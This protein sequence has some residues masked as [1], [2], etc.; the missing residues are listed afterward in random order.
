MHGPLAP[1]E[2]SGQ[3]ELAIDTTVPSSSVTICNSDGSKRVSRSTRTARS[4][5]VQMRLSRRPRPMR[6]GRRVGRTMRA[7]STCGSWRRRRTSSAL[8][9]FTRRG[10]LLLTS[11]WVMSRRT[12][13]SAPSPT[14]IRSTRTTIHKPTR[15]SLAPVHEAARSSRKR[16]L[17]KAQRAQN[18]SSLIFPGPSH[19]NRGST[20]TRTPRCR[21]PAWR[22]PR[23]PS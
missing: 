11:T 16:L 13:A 17:V 12:R 3:D 4:Q 19:G 7:T 1:S 22:S 20:S 21:T 15:I 2:G 6:S 23:A 9:T 18:V 5:P 8:V 14:L 10:G